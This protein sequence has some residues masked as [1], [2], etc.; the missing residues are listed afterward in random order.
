MT[1]SRTAR[2]SRA[3]AFAPTATVARKVSQRRRVA[4]ARQRRKDKNRFQLDALPSVQCGVR[5]SLKPSRPV[6]CGLAVLTPR[7]TT[8]STLCCSCLPTPSLRL[9]Y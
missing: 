4:E 1:R 6:P 2:E 3:A 7:P 9:L 5:K 8:M